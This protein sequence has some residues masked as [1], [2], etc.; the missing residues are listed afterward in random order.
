VAD[1]PPRAAVGGCKRVSAVFAIECTFAALDQGYWWFAAALT[2]IGVAA[3][4]LTNATNSM[5]R[6]DPAM[7][8]RV[9]T[10]RL[11]VGLGGASTNP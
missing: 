9:M 7:R 4:T 11:A 8:G 2:I 5:M 3:L 6:Q 10:L 1:N